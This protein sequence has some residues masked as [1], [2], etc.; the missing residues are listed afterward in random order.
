M[1]YIGFT[2][3]SQLPF[4]AGDEVY[5]FAGTQI[6]SS[7][8]KCMRYIQKKRTKVKIKKIYCGLDSIG[9]LSGLSSVSGSGATR[10]KNPTVE[11]VGSGGYRKS[12][13]INFIS[14]DKHLPEHMS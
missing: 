9:G 13:D 10:V 6:K 14:K 12:C 3:L 11:W 1:K 8:P 2:F 7:H 5:I 4:K